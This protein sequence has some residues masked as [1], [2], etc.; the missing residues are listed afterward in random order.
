MVEDGLIAAHA[1]GWRGTVTCLESRP[2]GEGRRLA[3][4]WAREGIAARW[5][6]DRERRSA[7]RASDA[8]LVGAD[9]ILADGSLV[10]KV[11]TR[12]LAREA[13]RAGVPFLVAAG[14]SKRVPFARLPRPLPARFDRTPAREIAGFLTDRGG[15][16]PRPRPASRSN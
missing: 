10:H 11:G 14:R 4:R 13:R 15:T 6:P 5:V 16:A 2:G 9:A 1:A 7:V 3:A 8:V 12:A